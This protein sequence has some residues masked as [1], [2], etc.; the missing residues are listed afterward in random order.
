[1]IVVDYDHVLIRNEAERVEVVEHIVDGLSR[2][3]EGSDDE[4]LGSV[5][6]EE[7][8]V[9]VGSCGHGESPMIKI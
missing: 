1:M 8:R 6:D 9:D 2:V 3:S 5:E 4:V 7:Q